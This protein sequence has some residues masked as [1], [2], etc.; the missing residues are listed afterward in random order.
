MKVEIFGKI[1][2][3]KC[4]DKKHWLFFYSLVR[5]FELQRNFCRKYNKSAT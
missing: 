2:K 1:S 4:A 5:A 3:E